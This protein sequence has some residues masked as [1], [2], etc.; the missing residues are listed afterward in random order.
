M[1]RTKCA[2]K[3]YIIVVTIL[4]IIVIDKISSSYCLYIKQQ[5]LLSE[6]SIFF[7]F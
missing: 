3:R 4:K 6:R 1:D 2:N 5:L 7:F